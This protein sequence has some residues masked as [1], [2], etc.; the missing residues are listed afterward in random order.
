MGRLTNDADRDKWKAWAR[1]QRY[2]SYVMAGLIGV[3]AFLMST[4]PQF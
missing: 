4:K 2:L 1:R 3:I